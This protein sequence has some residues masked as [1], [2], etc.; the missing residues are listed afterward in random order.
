MS[1]NIAYKYR[2]GDNGIFERDLDALNKNYFWAPNYLNLNDPCETLVSAKTIK[3]QIDTFLKLPSFKSISAEHLYSA[4]DKMIN[5]R[6]S[7]GIYS[8]S[9]SHDHELLWAYYAD[10]HKGFCIQYDLDLLIK[11]N[12]YQELHH[13]PVIYKNKPPSITISDISKMEMGNLFQKL[14]GTKSKLWEHE[15][16][17]RIITDIIGENDY[18]YSAITAI[19]FGY[20]MPDENKEKIMNLLKGRGI[21]Y[22]QM[23]LKDKSYQFKAHPIKDKF[24]KNK[25]Y[26]F[27]ILEKTKKINYSILDKSYNQYAKKGTIEIQLQEKITEKQL[28]EIGSDLEKKLFRKA[29][30][31]FMSYFLPKEINGTETWATTHCELGDFKIRIIGFSLEQELELN[32]FLKMDTRNIIGR[33]IDYSSFVSHGLILFKENSNF[34]LERKCSDGSSFIKELKPSKSNGGIRYEEVEENHHGEYFIIDETGY[35][36]YFSHEGE[37]LKLKPYLSY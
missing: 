4:L 26:L 17:F 23:F 32:K 14:F 22:Y 10:S 7:V 37:F 9:N 12:I 8:L 11:K 25:P 13:F 6:S 1:H 21:K 18:D 31:V 34:F 5:K 33:W 27:Q 16:E 36:H 24:N 35:L 30:R 28:H 20:R 19:Y 3:L 29:D 2:G 15:K